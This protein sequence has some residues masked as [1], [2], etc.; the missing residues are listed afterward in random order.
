MPFMQVHEAVQLIQMEYQEMPDLKL[1][2]G[3]ARR[4]WNL[5]NELCESAL[6]LLTGSGFLAQTADGHYV[7]RGDLSRAYEPRRRRTFD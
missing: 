4:L 6:T 3:Q 1:T 7:R 5:S 2:F